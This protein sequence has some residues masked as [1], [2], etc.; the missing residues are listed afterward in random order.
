MKSDMTPLEVFAFMLGLGVTMLSASVLCGGCV[1]AP[2]ADCL[3]KHEQKA[4]QMTIH[5]S[6]EPS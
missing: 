2:R 4:E 1:Y 3:L 6:V 5:Q